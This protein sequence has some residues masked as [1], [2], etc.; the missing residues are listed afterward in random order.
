VPTARAWTGNV[1]I[2]HS[3]PYL[4]QAHF[5]TISR[6]VRMSSHWR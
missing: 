3:K 4:L 2:E 1:E 6:S 5:G